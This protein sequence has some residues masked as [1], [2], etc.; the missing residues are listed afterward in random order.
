MNPGDM[1][2]SALDFLQKDYGMKV[3]YLTAHFSRMW[4]RFNFFIALETALAGAL[5]TAMTPAWQVALAVRWI[6]AVGAASSL[7]WYVCG[8]EDRY[9]VEAY[10]GQVKRAGEATAHA[11]GLQDYVPI[12]APPA[13][14]QQSW[15]AYFYQWRWE[16]FSTTKLAAWIPLLVFLSWATAFV[17]SCH[18]YALKGGGR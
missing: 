2:Q 12:G 4:T 5:F 10:R 17:L 3:E 1:S 16:P 18:G 13:K 6:T 7:L 9:L 15:Y 11:L 8:A 14:I